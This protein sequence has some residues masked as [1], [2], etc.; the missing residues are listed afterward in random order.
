MEGFIPSHSL[1]LNHIQPMVD[2]ALDFLQDVGAGLAAVG[3]YAHR[4][5]GRLAAAAAAVVGVA[6]SWRVHPLVGTAVSVMACALVVLY[7]SRCQ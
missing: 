6:A 2:L 7:V 3:A 4:Y 5:P 1:P